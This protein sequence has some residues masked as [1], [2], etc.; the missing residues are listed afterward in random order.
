MSPLCQTEN[1]SDSQFCKKCATP[2]PSSKRVSV[3]KTLIT[4]REELTRGAIFAGRYEIIEELGRGGMGNVYRVYDK[5][6]EGEVALRHVKPDI[7]ADR[8]IILRFGNELKLARETAHRNVYRMYDL[9][10]AEA[11]HFITM[12]MCR[13]RI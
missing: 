12:E 13:Q 6:L 11:F 3:T 4:P 7:A 5:K 8:K 10:E 1:T 2:L 9:G